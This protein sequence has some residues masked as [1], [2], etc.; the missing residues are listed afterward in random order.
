VSTTV[1]NSPRTLSVEVEGGTWRLVE[2]P[3]NTTVQSAAGQRGHFVVYRPNGTA[4]L[5]WLLSDPYTHFTDEFGYNGK[6]YRTVWGVVPETVTR[7]VLVASSG[8]TL[9]ATP[10][11]GIFLMVTPDQAFVSVT[12]TCA[13]TPFARTCPSEFKLASLQYF[14]EEALLCSIGLTGGV[15]PRC[16]ER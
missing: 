16:P 3:L 9:S 15:V 6:F 12:Q 13:D 1:P 14:A 5:G 2:E 4:T 8:A 11:D 7:V 10:H